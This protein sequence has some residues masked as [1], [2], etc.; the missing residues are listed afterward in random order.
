VSGR[1]A[2]LT[3]ALLAGAAVS[4]T[5]RATACCPTPNAVFAVGGGASAAPDSWS[6]SSSAAVGSHY[7][8]YAKLFKK[9]VTA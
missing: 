6:T 7:L 4:A 3:V 8:R 1:L 5:A 9:G 2:L